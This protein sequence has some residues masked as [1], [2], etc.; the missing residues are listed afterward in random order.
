MQGADGRHN[1]NNLLR[2]LNVVD[3]PKPIRTAYNE[4]LRIHPLKA[5][6]RLVFAQSAFDSGGF[7]TP[8]LIV[9]GVNDSEQIADEV[10]DSWYDEVNEEIER[11]LAV[12][13]V[14]ASSNYEVLRRSVWGRILAHELGHALRYVGVKTPFADEE[15]AADCIAGF[16]DGRRGKSLKLGEILFSSIGCEGSACTHPPPQERRT[17]YRTGYYAALRASQVSEQYR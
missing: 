6:P 3:T 17:A 5:P 15:A 7:F 1:I 10:W 11:L 4:M 16:F 14:R 2:V 9:I 8:G 12:K 13:G